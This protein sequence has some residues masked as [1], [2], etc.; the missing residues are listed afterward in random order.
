MKKLTLFKEERLQDQSMYVKVVL[1]T[2]SAFLLITFCAMIPYIIQGGAMWILRIILTISGIALFIF[3]INKFR[4]IKILIAIVV[5]LLSAFIIYD[6]G[7]IKGVAIFGAILIILR[8][9]GISGNFV[10][11]SNYRK[12][13]TAYNTGDA[14]TAIEN[15][16]ILFKNNKLKGTQHELILILCQM[17]NYT[18]QYSQTRQL[19]DK[20]KDSYHEQTF[21]LALCSYKIRALQMQKRIP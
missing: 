10:F 11:N 1:G 14:E 20:Y 13:I 3:V 6:I 5:F 8:I 21:Q 18:H 9:L 19:I 16:E 2:F 15:F 12:A 17:Y 7:G 4:L